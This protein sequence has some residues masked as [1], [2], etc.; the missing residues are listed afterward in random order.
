MG[1]SLVI[2]IDVSNFRFV[3]AFKRVLHLPARE[4][5]FNLFVFV[6][7]CDREVCGFVMFCMTSNLIE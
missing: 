5:C 7:L 3:V 6:S 1:F 2:S 4:V